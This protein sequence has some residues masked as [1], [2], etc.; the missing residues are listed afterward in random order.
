MIIT[1]MSRLKKNGDNFC[2]TQMSALLNNEGPS[3]KSAE[4]WPKVS[5]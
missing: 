5:I 2:W 3:I 4:R 1:E